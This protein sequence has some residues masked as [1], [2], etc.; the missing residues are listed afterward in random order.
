VDWDPERVGVSEL[1]QLLD[2]IAGEPSERLVS[3]LVLRSMPRAVYSPDPRGHFA[4]AA[5]AYAHFTSPIRRYPDRGV[6]RLL[7]ELTDGPG[8]LRGDAYE[9]AEQRLVRLGEHCS[10]RE[11]RAEA[12]ERMAVQW[13]TME[14]LADRVGEVAEGR[15]SGVTD[16]GLFVQ[17]DEFAIDGLVH[18]GELVDDYYEHDPVSH[19]LVGSRTG[20]RWRLGDP[21][22]V[23]MA[24]VD[25]DT[26][27]LQL[28]PVG[29][30]PDRKAVERP[31]RRRRPKRPA[32]PRAGTR[33]PAKAKTPRRP[34]AKKKGR[35][36]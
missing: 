20:R 36:R 21:I 4:L 17:L 15:V 31:D 22:R 19:S 32:P 2:D 13:R 35:R 10:A 12:A 8:P 11:Q 7:R 5:D 3:M 29:V 27:Q 18:I 30:K 24:R 26:M 23:R 33:P 6:H 34:P 28:I 14:F 9:A 16:F 1:Q 25:L